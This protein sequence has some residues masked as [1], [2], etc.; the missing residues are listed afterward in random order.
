MAMTWP[1]NGTVIRPI[2]AG[3][4]PCLPCAWFYVVPRGVLALW[5]RG[6][7]QKTGRLAETKMLGLQIAPDLVADQRECTMPRSLA[8]DA[9][10][11]DHLC[12]KQG[13]HQRGTIP[14]SGSD[15]EPSGVSRIPAADGEDGRGYSQESKERVIVERKKTGAE[16]GMEIGRSLSSRGAKRRCAV[17]PAKPQFPYEVEP[18]WGWPASESLDSRPS[19]QVQ[20]LPPFMN[21]LG[22][23]GLSPSLYTSLC[24]L[25]CWPAAA[26]SSSMGVPQG[27][28]IEG[29][30][31]PR[32]E[33]WMW[34]LA[35]MGDAGET[36]SSEMRALST[37]VL[38]RAVAD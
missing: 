23:P 19:F 37:L 21:P 35:M 25:C 3:C 15:V 17:S 20:T 22:V 27:R 38:A 29:P 32:N 18:S 4:W 10:R 8:C 13:R 1:G 24:P 2:R 33:S 31:V 34:T 6:A 30:T 12:R 9:A 36:F 26:A 16:K 7:P 11:L 14:P 5:S 28:L